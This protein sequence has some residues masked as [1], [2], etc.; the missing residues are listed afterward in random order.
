VFLLTAPQKF[1][2]DAIAEYQRILASWKW[3][4]L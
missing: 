2:K 3:T 4:R 1:R